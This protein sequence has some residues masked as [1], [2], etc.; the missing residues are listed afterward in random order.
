MIERRVVIIKCKKCGK[1]GVERTITK[2]SYNT[3][4]YIFL[5]GLPIRGYIFGDTCSYLSIGFE[6]IDPYNHGIRHGD[7]TIRCKKC[8][9][10]EIIYG[11]EKYE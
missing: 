3:W 6:Y 8:G 11:G 5:M 10:V 7:Y 2:D 1:T 4:D 9:S